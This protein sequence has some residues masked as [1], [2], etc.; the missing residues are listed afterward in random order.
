MRG[1]PLIESAND[2]LSP[3]VP[4]SRVD[5]WLIKATRYDDNGYP[6]RWIRSAIPSNS[7][8]C[9]WA[10]V[11]DATSRGVF[12]AGVDVQVHAIDETNRRVDIPAILKS[13][14]A[15]GTRAIVMLVGVQTNQYPR[16]MDIA[17]PLRQ[18]GV[19][20]C[21]GGFHVSGCVAMLGEDA[22]ELALARE[23]GVSQFAGEA[24]PDRLDAVLQDALADTLKPLYNHLKKEPVLPGS[25]V[26]LLPGPIVRRSFTHWSSFDLGRGCPFECSFCTIIN[27]QGRH[28]RFRT[29]DELE[30]I[31]RLN[32]AAGVTKF[33][34]TDDNFARN[35]NWEAYCDRLIE[36]REREGLEVR[37]L[38][39]V[40]TMAHRIPGFIDKVVKAGV[41]LIFIGLENIN[42]DNL[43]AAKKRQNRIEEYREMVLDWK[44]HPVVVSC[45]Y[46]IGFP[47]D[48]RE[49][50]LRDVDLIKRELAIDV[51]YFN[52]LTPLPGSED[53]KKMKDAGVWMDPDFNKY[54]LN[55][56][57][58][59]HARMSDAELDAVF[60]EASA[61][62]YDFEHMERVFKRRVQL[63]NGMRLT[64][65]YNLIAYREGPR[66]EGVAFAE[67]GL[68]RI[69]DRHERRHG[70]PLEN[71]IP[72]YARYAW[73]FARTIAAY[74]YTYIR[75]RLSVA[76]AWRAWGRQD[77][78]PYSDEAIAA[79]DM[80]NDPLVQETAARSTAYT[81]RRQE[82]RLKARLGE[83]TYT[84]Q[85]TE[86][87]GR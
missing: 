24:E 52:I 64:T 87:A 68:G 50:I 15:E 57:V 35:R 84:D 51:L 79:V 49:S 18:A 2:S 83:A 37:L 41:R 69:I 53:H 31:V 71:P 9:V 27:V 48:T 43:E 78:F 81:K 29:A 75:L 80:R 86:V 25:P 76:K 45:G 7:L 13:H 28:S 77:L 30:R 44:R 67:F 63:K 11:D 46:I 58:T 61:R 40:D 74:A 62:Y 12:G 85:G 65:L 10:L 5:I 4:I 54:D 20:V 59:H 6:I 39:Q 8:A 73:R 17:R 26:P 23:L 32:A 16:A 47:A 60:H 36:L 38:I 1:H 14:H 22:E 19:P 66:R 3:T 82:N 72:F 33:F 56:R 21:I 42:P 34:V 55:H 70:M